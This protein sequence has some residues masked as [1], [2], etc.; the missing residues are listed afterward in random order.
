MV[1]TLTDFGRDELIDARREKRQL[2]AGVETTARAI[3]RLM[4]DRVRHMEALRKI[5]QATETGIITQG[6]A[7]VHRLAREAL[8]AEADMSWWPEAEDGH[9]G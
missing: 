8:E 6:G 5:A 1:R 4:E 3:G 2:L 7:H 9:A